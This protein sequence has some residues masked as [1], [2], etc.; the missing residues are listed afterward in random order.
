MHGGIN[1]ID[2]KQNVW[3]NLVDSVWEKAGALKEEHSVLELAGMHSVWK[4]LVRQSFL[5]H[6]STGWGEHSAGLFINTLAT[7]GKNDAECGEESR[8]QI[9]PKADSCQSEPSVHAANL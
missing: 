4:S 7:N 5:S 8:S 3:C 9:S 6:P 2:P 1:K